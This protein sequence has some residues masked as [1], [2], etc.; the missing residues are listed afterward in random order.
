MNKE[1]LHQI[2][3]AP[4]V[5]EKTTV[6]GEQHNQAVFKVLPDANKTEIREA[7]EKL[8]NVSVDSVRT[9]NV[10]GKTKMFGR[11]PG[12]RSNWKKAYVSLAQGSEIEFVGE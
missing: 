12:R 9:V 6:V 7:V 4:V 5:T 11:R 1:R 3:L 10:K 8:F 2:L